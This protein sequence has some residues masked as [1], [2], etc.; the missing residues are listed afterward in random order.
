MNNAT[1]SRLE[2]KRPRA[3]L[4]GLGLDNS[5][6]HTRITRGKNFHLAGGA[7]DTHERMQEQAIKFNEKLDRQ[8]RH[9]EDISRKEFVDLAHDVGMTIAPDDL[10]DCRRDNK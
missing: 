4:I 3:L 10:D 8:G 5:D 7:E 9:L 2:W 1:K 6:G